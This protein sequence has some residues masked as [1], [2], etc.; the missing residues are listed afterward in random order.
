MKNAGIAAKIEQPIATYTD[1]VLTAT[2]LEE[3]MI[4]QPL[5]PQNQGATTQAN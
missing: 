5:I 2:S 1:K 3:T 4:Y